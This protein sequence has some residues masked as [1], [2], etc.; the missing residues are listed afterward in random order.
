MRKNEIHPIIQALGVSNEAKTHFNEI[1]LYEIMENNIIFETADDPWYQ[2][3]ANWCE[4]SVALKYCTKKDLQILY[5]SIIDTK[6]KQIQNTGQDQ[7]MLFYAW[8]DPMGA[9]GG[10]LNFS[11][12]SPGQWETLPFRSIAN[13]VN[14][15]D[16]ILEEFIQCPYKGTIRIDE[17]VDVDPA[18]E[19]DDEPECIVNV[20][21]TI[22]P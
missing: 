9:L 6:S 17:L 7:K 12:I 21:S 13:L 5:Q 20:W 11:L 4:F 3:R 16:D 22:L 14:S 10:T 15:M 19:D 2:A 1:K 8:Y 18:E